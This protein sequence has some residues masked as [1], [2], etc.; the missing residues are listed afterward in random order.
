LGGRRGRKLEGKKSWDA[1]ALLG[2]RGGSKSRRKAQKRG[3]K[4]GTREKSL[5][6]DEKERVSKDKRLNQRE[7][8]FWK[9]NK[10]LR[11]A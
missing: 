10:D 4:G 7:G 9:M 6:K 2:G 11:K 8:L 1:Q 5:N 3:K